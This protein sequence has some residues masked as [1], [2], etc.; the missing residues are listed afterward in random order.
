MRRLPF[1]GNELPF[2]YGE[3]TAFVIHPGITHE[4]ASLWLGFTP[5]RLPD[6]DVTIEFM[7]CAED[8]A[9]ERGSLTV[10]IHD[11]A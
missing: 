8:L 10:F 1:T 9:L 11:L 4:V 7:V 2:R 3:D 5:Q 6:Q